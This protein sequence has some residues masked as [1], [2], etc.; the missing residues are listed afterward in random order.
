MVDFELEDRPSFG[1]ASAA[2]AMHL[3]SI[4]RAEAALEH[5]L[6]GKRGAVGAAVAQNVA[7]RD[8]R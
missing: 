5:T 6:G 8:H 1:S 4:D 7:R 2:G 3:D